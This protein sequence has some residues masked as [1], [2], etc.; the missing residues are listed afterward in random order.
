MESNRDST[1]AA[2]EP[3]ASLYFNAVYL[4]PNNAGADFL[5]PGASHWPDRNRR[6]ASWARRCG[7][8]QRDSDG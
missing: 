1:T 7:K 8:R 3:V 4:T 5:S 6:A 2:A